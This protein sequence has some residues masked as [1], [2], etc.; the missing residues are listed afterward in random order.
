MNK[1]WI[2]GSVAI[3]FSLGLAAQAQQHVHGQGN[4]FIAQQ[5]SQLS[6]QLELAAADAL[7]FEHTAETA[8]QIAQQRELAKRLQAND[9]VIEFNEQ[10]E[11]LSVVHSLDEDG[12]T[13]H[14]PTDPLLHESHHEDE[15][16]EEGSHKNIDVMYQFQC[17]VGVNK[18]SIAL[19]SSMPSL[20]SLQAQWVTE[21]GQGAAQLSA[22]QPSLTW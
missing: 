10:C 18:V 12:N 6:V 9:A 19:F 1:R 15:H 4:L 20:T 22:A 14:E 17:E 8:Q 7:G 16:E 3:F 13:S 11:L 5:G 21:N 2:R